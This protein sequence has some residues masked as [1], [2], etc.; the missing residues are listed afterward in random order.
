MFKHNA[1]SLIELL[2]VVTIIGVLS[3]LAIPTYNRYVVRAKGT[4]LIMVALQAQ[5]KM[6]ENY[7]EDSVWTNEADLGLTE[8][9]SPY[10]QL[11]QAKPVGIG[12]CQ[13]TGGQLIG[14]VKVQA[15]ANHMN[16]FGDMTLIKVGCSQGGFI[17][18]KCGTTAATVESKN[19]HYLPAECRTIIE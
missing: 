19:Q 7:L 10:I 17:T 12:D 4:D 6:V 2:M 13:E 1:F 15:D 5:Q 14:G 11:I 3:S 18:W 8:H 9:V 16:L